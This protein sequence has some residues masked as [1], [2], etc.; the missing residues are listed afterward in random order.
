MLLALPASAMGAAQFTINKGYVTGNLP[1]FATSIGPPQADPTPGPDSLQAGAYPG[2]GTFQNY[3]WSPLPA[4]DD[5]KNATTNFG[6]GLLANPQSVPKCPQAELAAGGKNCPAGS[7]IGTSRFQIGNVAVGTTAGSLRGLLYNSEP[8]A[9]KPGQLATITIASEAGFGLNPPAVGSYSYL[10][11]P[12]TL[13]PRGSKDYGLTGVTGDITRPPPACGGGC[14]ATNL[15]FF[16]NPGYTRNPTSCEINETTGSAVGYD[17][18][19]VVT[20]PNYYFTPTGCSSVPFTPTMSMEIG[21]TGEN[22]INGYPPMTVKINNGNGNADI[23]GNVIFLPIQL[24][25][26]NTNYKLCT[27][28]Q[29]DSD[30]CPADSQFGTTT[31]TSPFLSSALSGPVYLIQQSSGSLPGLLLDLN[32]LA[33]IKLQTQSFLGQNNQQ[34]VS[35][36]NKA[37]QLPVSELT[38]NLGSGKTGSVFQNRADLCLSNPPVNSTFQNYSDVSG[39]DGWNGAYTATSYSAKVNGCGPSVLAKLSSAQTS[40]PKLSMTVERHPNSPNMKTL[41]VD[42]PKGLS[43]S[44]KQFNKASAEFSTK[45]SNT[46]FKRI[47]SRKLQVSGLPAAGAKKISISLKNGALT[48]SKSKQKSL[49]KGR[50]LTFKFRA[51]DTQVTSGSIATDSTISV[52]GTRKGSRRPRTRVNFVG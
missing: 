11:I 39:F 22:A 46:Q 43:I 26:N 7:Q 41:D 13:T 44:K 40:K 50:R 47:S 24:N 14:V 29:A 18:P 33:H 6:P 30:S 9:G 36:L 52:K 16:A 35:V 21:K 4:T 15:S 32:G 31:A 17:N 25:S 19:E 2:A 48:I 49:D 23:K 8:D 12:F 34:I 5:V 1:N 51:N 28:A 42:L 27:Q 38:V 45:A 20:Q 3:V 10:P 37:P